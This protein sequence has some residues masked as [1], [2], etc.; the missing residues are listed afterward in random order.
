VASATL[1]RVPKPAPAA[2]AHNSP[3]APRIAV[4]VPYFQREA[5]LLRRA[6]ASVAAQEHKAAQVVVVDDGS[7]RPASEEI[8]ADLRAALP[9]LTMIRQSNL[10]IAA[11]R[12]A[13]LD[14]LGDSVSAI[15]LLD[16]D[17]RWESTH[18]RH[19]A[20]ALT[21]GADFFFS[22]SRVEGESTD[23]F[24]QHPR[25]DRLCGPAPIQGSGGIV[26]WGD[27]ISALFGAGCAFTTSSVVFR[28]A[29]APG[30]R[31]SQRFRRAGEDQ[32]AFWDVLVRASAIMFHGDPTVIMGRGGMG[33]WRN[34]NLGSVAHLVRLSD[35]ITLRRS[36]LRGYPVS[37]PDRQLMRRAIAN[38]RDAALYSSLHLLRRRRE[39]TVR[40]ILHLLRSDPGCVPK[41]CVRLPQLLYRYT[42]GRPRGATH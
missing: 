33:T 31:F 2:A 23:Y 21:L 5:G 34:S 41:W 24:H 30:L 15:A 13:A 1:E 10:G 42:F 22:N 3:A 38:R 11:A 20:A 9:G 26:R 36:V 27:A 7:P 4:V 32:L 28:R 25:R 17:D 35:E 29:V 12:N 6:L 18:L 14:A 19:A 37:A 39:G 16:S 8:G 40:E